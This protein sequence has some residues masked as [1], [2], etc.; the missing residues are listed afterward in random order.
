VINPFL[1]EDAIMSAAN[2]LVIHGWHQDQTQAL[3]KYYG[4]AEGYPRAVFAYAEALKAAQAASAQGPS[5][6]SPAQ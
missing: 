4:T 2:Y 6:G 5:F 1:M 3:G